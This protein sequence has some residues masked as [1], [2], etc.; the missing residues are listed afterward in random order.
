[1]SIVLSAQ[2]HGTMIHG[3]QERSKEQ[4]LTPMC[5]R[6]YLTTKLQI[7]TTQNNNKLIYFPA[8]W[9]LKEESMIHDCTENC[10]QESVF[11]T[12]KNKLEY[13]CNIQH[14]QKEEGSGINNQ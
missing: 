12:T 10:H 2:K 4:W 7:F 9:I 6:S 5:E 14:H 13:S 8:H 1:M 3:S 11:S